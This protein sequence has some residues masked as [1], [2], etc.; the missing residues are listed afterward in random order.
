MPRRHMAPVPSTTLPD[1]PLGAAGAI[2]AGHGECAGSP[3]EIGRWV[4]LLADLIVAEVI[5]ESQASDAS[6]RPAGYPVPGDE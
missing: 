4:D 3:E 1:A 2:P 6:M 5:R